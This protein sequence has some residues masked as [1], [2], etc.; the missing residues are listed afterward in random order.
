MKKIANYINKNG[1]YI[2]LVLIEAYLI[3][4]LLFVYK[5]NIINHL[6]NI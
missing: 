5:I 2:S 1:Y 3:N 4:I 6:T